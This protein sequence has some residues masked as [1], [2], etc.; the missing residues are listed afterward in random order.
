MIKQINPHQEILNAALHAL[1][2]G[3]RREL[4]AITGFQQ[5]VVMDLAIGHLLPDLAQPTLVCLIIR[6]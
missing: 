2:S 4:P 3:G 5:V 1:Q 6:S